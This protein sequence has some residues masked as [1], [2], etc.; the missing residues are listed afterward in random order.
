MSK[1]R[2][3]PGPPD[4]SCIECGCMPSLTSGVTIYPHRTDLHRKPFW[5]CGC[6][7]YVGCHPGTETPLGRPAGP[8]TRAA[9]SRAHAEF[10]AIWRRKAL[11]D[12]VSNNEARRLGYAW[13]AG[14]MG[15]EPGLCHIGWMSAE[16]AN[17]VVEVCTSYRRVPA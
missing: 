16:D 12:G 8:K 3:P 15:L 1:H 4:P 14:R 2:L 9:R 13:L 17:R 11:R 5:R 6:G 10:D 7:A